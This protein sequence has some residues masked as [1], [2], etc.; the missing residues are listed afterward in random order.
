MNFAKH[1]LKL[2][3]LPITL[4]CSSLNAEETSQPNAEKFC[5]ISW[6]ENDPTKIAAI[7]QLQIPKNNIKKK[8]RINELCNTIGMKSWAQFRNIEKSK[9]SINS[10]IYFTEEIFLNEKPYEI[11]ISIGIGSGYFDQGRNDIQKTVER[12]CGL[13]ESE[14]FPGLLK[15]NKKNTPPCKPNDLYFGNINSANPVRFTCPPNDKNCIA[16]GFFNGWRYLAGKIDQEAL[17]YWKSAHE[18]IE[19]KMSQRSALLTSETECFGKLCDD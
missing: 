11:Q 15:Q 4:S 7:L 12:I 2:V 16:I 5:F 6:D 8:F 10:G 1:F 3:C 18:Q 14:E 9:Y 17:R 13:K 19:K